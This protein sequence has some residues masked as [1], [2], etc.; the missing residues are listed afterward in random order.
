MAQPGPN[1][2]MNPVRLEVKSEI[3]PEPEMIAEP[4]SQMAALACCVF[5]WYSSKDFLLPLTSAVSSDRLFLASFSASGP[6]LAPNTLISDCS[7]AS[8]AAPFSIA[9]SS[10]PPPSMRTS[11]IN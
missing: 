7:V 2:A 6:V 3:F 5:F 4:K 11:A 10:S 1:V 8:V 9:P